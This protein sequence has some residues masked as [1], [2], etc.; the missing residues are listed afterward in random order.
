MNVHRFTPEHRTDAYECHVVSL[1][2]SPRMARNSY[3]S[4][5]ASGLR[6]FLARLATIGLWVET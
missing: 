1:D 2:I 6:P 3:R 4:Y 5:R